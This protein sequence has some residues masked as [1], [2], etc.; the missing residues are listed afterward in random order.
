L[1]DLPR[2][3]A[4]AGVF[5]LLIGRDGTFGPIAGIHFG[6]VWGRLRDCG[7]RDQDTNTAENERVNG[8]PETV[9]IHI[10]PPAS[11]DAAED[12]VQMK[13]ARTTVNHCALPSLRT[14]ITA[15]FMS[16]S[17]CH[18]TCAALCTLEHSLQAGYGLDELAW[19]PI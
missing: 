2:E 7:H 1:P 9:L 16:V 4:I 17:L 18:S 14:S 12:L 15:H 3:V 13:R 10:L 5:L 6:I 19:Q 8:A 11:A